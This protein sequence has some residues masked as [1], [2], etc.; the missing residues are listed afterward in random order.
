MKRMPR[1]L[2]LS[3]LLAN[4]LVLGCD[5]G[6][7]DLSAPIPASAP[8]PLVDLPDGTYSVDFTTDSPMFHVNEAYEGKSVMTVDS[9]RATLHLVLPSKNVVNL[10]LGKAEDARRPGATLLFP[11]DERVVYSDGVA[12]TVYAYE[13]PVPVIDAEFNV[14]LVGRKGNWYDHRAKVSNP[15]P[16]EPP[17]SSV[18]LTPGE[19]LIPVAL[20]GGSGR[21]G[22]ESPVKVVVGDDGFHVALK[23]SSSNYDYMIVDGARYDASVVD[24]RSVFEFAVPDLSAPL[25]VVADS[26]AMSRPHEIEYTLR[27]D[28]SKAVPV[29]TSA[30]STAEVQDAP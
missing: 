19:Y 10:F 28:L 16:V 21:G 30:E 1:R 3:C 4:A 22:V 27:F 7:D 14:A 11:S 2:F 6:G 26:V 20:E 12:E 24:G 29:P 15:V 5:S 18:K 9:G 23:W 17:A 13:L 25:A 8:V